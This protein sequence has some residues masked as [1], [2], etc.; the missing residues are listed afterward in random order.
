MFWDLAKSFV[1]LK[2][3]R[4]CESTMCRKLSI[5]L[6]KHLKQK[7]ISKRAA[8]QKP[9][10]ALLYIF[11]QVKS[12]YLWTQSIFC[13]FFFLKIT[14]NCVN[15]LQDR[16]RLK[17]TETVRSWL[18]AS[19]FSNCRAFMKELSS[20]NI[21]FCDNFEIWNI[22]LVRFFQLVYLWVMG[23]GFGVA[24]LDC[25]EKYGI[26]Q[27]F[28]PGRWKGQFYQPLRGHKCSPTCRRV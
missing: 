3:V 16:M 23:I 1:L 22:V 9:I 7:E 24:D 12:G 17:K 2:W 19:T 6:L 25:G 14:D 27:S 26:M 4:R 13:L 10:L 28:S 5:R 15:L 11:S 8:L 20:V 18:G 21:P